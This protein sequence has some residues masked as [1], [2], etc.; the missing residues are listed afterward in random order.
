VPP[1]EVVL[2]PAARTVAYNVTVAES[3]VSL[4]VAE[5]T[6]RF[7]ALTRVGI[8]AVAY[9]S[10]MGAACAAWHRAAGTT[11]AWWALVVSFAPAL[12]AL[13]CA[14]TAQHDRRQYVARLMAATLMG[15]LLVLFWSLDG[16][17]RPGLGMALAIAFAL[18]HGAVFV[19][20]V[21]WL[22]AF[23][24]QIAPEGAAEGA[25]APASPAMLLR[26]LASLRALGLPLDVRETAPGPAQWLQIS[27]HPTGQPGRVHVVQLRLDAANRTVAVHEC[28]QAD[29]AA[30]ADADEASMRSP[31]EPA[32]DPA[33]PA[34]Q[35][36][37]LRTVQATMLDDQRLRDVPLALQDERA[38]WTGADSPALADTDALM[39]C[40]AAIVT[41]SGWGWRPRLG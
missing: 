37:W 4:S 20:A 39:A 12:L 33:R 19:L 11:P 2:K 30:P 5:P 25:A 18:L 28:L 34:A 23:T 9:T 32:I 3:R 7:P 29:G 40:L 14:L 22:A 16:P 26:R 31:G 38:V 27:W 6:D 21:W 24:T 35:R 1:H 8:A 36:V 10:L 13:S 17:T 15:P 41:R